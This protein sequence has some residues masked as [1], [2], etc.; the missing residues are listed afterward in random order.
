MAIIAAHSFYLVRFCEN[1]S[2]GDT[3]WPQHWHLPTSSLGLEAAGLATP[4]PHS[5]KPTGLAAVLG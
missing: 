1:K 3:K 4:R 2:E 5:E